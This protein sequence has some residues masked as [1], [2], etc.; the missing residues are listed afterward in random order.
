[1]TLKVGA[2]YLMNP[3]P[4][5]KFLN[6]GLTWYVLYVQTMLLFLDNPNLLA[7]SAAMANVDRKCG[8]KACCGTASVA[9]ERKVKTNKECYHFE[10]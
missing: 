5:L 6:S 10:V 8:F 7:W 2:N 1:M 9:T 4:A 3:V